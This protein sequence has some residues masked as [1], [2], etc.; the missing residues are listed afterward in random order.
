M[1]H[2]RVPAVGWLSARGTMLHRAVW[3]EDEDEPR[4]AC[5]PDSLVL[6][7]EATLDALAGRRSY[8]RCRTC[9]DLRH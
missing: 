7:V 1:S 9:E 6:S 2:L 8:R 4:A 5:R 3:R